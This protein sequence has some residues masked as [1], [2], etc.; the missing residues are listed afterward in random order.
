MGYLCI[1]HVSVYRHY[2]KLCPACIHNSIFDIVIACNGPQRTQ[3]LL[4]KV[5]DAKQTDRQ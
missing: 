4:N 5:L 3:H 2:N 1:T